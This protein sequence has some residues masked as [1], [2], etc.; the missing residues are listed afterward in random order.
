MPRD[1]KK[2]FEEHHHITGSAIGSARIF[3]AKGDADSAKRVLDECCRKIDLVTIQYQP[4]TAKI[5]GLT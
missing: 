1:D 2:Y 4:A 5:M 3:L